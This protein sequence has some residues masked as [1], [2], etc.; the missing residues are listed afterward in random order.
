[1]GT[2]ASL[3]DM[4]KRNFLTSPG[5]Y[6]DPSVVQPVSSR[7][8]DCVTAA[9]VMLKQGSEN[10][11][12]RLSHLLDV[13]CLAATVDF[14]GRIMD[15]YIN[16]IAIALGTG[17]KKAESWTKLEAEHAAPHKSVVLYKK[18]HC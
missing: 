4:E 2:I 7:Y 10:I 16:V 15:T 11:T 1:M 8:T 13:S 12:R 14:A 17:S 5:S 3:D 9:L 6:S 18:K